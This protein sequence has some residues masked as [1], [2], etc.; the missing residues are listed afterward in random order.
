M[1]QAESQAYI[2]PVNSYY[3]VDNDFWGLRPVTPENVDSF[4]PPVNSGEFLE[5]NVFLN[6]FEEVIF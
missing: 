6:S 2:H 5:N 4:K 1:I 3:D